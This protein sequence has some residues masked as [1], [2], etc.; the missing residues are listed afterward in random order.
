MQTIINRAL[1]QL[2]SIYAPT[3]GT[4][5][6]A[7]LGRVIDT[8]QLVQ[9]AYVETIQLALRSLMQGDLEQSHD[10]L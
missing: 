4:P 9:D 10:I 6:D 2:D 5:D 7:S 8:L 3:G 1:D